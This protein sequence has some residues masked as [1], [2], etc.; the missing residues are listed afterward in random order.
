MPCVV[1]IDDARR[2]SVQGQSHASLRGLVTCGQTLNTRRTSN[3]E[4]AVNDGKPTVGALGD[5]E[6]VASS[7][8][9]RLISRP[10]G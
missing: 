2:G 3:A 4:V 7:S 10:D 5:L 8:L 9:V 6:E 1:D